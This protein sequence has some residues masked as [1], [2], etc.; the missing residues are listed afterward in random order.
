[1]AAPEGLLGMISPDRK[2]APQTRLRATIDR[3]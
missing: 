1:L 2:K 3:M